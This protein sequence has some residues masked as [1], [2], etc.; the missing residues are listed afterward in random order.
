M[1]EERN[2]YVASLGATTALGRTWSESLS[3]LAAGESAVERVRTFD[4]DGFPSQY[5]AGIASV[6]RDLPDRREALVEMALADLLKTRPLPACLPERR[7]IFLGAESGRATP[8]TV[9]ALSRAAGGSAHFDHSSFGKKAQE[10]AG[11][12]D[13]RS[14]SPAATASWLA[15]KLAARGPNQTISIACASGAIAIAH[16]ARAIRLGVCD[17]ALAG[18]VG[19]DVDPLMLVGFGKLGAL[20]EKGIS[21]P[22]DLQRDGFIVGEG[23]ALVLLTANREDSIGIELTG[24]GMSLDAYHLTAPDPAGSGAERA[25][26]AAL[27]DS[28]R[29]SIDYI[30][31]HGTSTPLNDECEALAISRCFEQSPP[32]ASVKG[33]LGHWIA[34]A[35]ALGFLCGCAAIQGTQLATAGLEELDP[36]CPINAPRGQA[37]WAP[38]QSALINSFAF[39]GANCSLIVEAQ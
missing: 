2:V 13:A 35:G 8:Q 1:P 4:V 22:F 34:G 20:S 18:G 36:R 24:I 32:V 28:E 12:I 7:G 31:A 23:A 9:L 17:Q 19:A 29:T 15:Q 14:V 11:L 27:R 33:A 38:V 10:L 5:A 16:A 6:S 21:R 37:L 39:G 30:Q 26:R 25:M 3:R